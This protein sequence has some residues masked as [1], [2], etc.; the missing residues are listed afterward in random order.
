MRV[1]TLGRCACADVVS[2]PH[3]MTA[4]VMSV[5]GIGGGDK[6]CAKALRR[7]FHC[8]CPP[9]VL[10]RLRHFLGFLGNQ[11]DG[12]TRE[13]KPQKAFIKSFRCISVVYPYEQGVVA[14][15]SAQ[16]TKYMYVQYT[17]QKNLRFAIC[18]PTTSSGLWRSSTADNNNTSAKITC[19]YSVGVSTMHGY[20]L[21][22]SRGQR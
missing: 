14:P 7:S 19:M 22:L 15:G 10:C 21:T 8:L 5:L 11:Q 3:L 4:L 18:D 2:E 20:N 1:T 9:L 13:C 12:S 16:R 17:N 6:R